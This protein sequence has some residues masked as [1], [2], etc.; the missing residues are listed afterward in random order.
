MPK[1]SIKMTKVDH[2]GLKIVPLL[3]PVKRLCLLRHD[4]FLAG[5]ILSIT[6]HHYKSLLFPQ[7]LNIKQVNLG[8]KMY[9]KHYIESRKRGTHITAALFKNR[10]YESF[11]L[12]LSA[13]FLTIANNV[14]PYIKSEVAD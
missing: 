6:S 12:L 13:F 1:Y 8:F 5:Q 3:A 9:M 10:H 7:C 2:S 14:Q 11:I 4:P